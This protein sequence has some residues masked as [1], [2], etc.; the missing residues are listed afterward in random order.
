MTDT[1]DPRVDASIAALPAWQQARCRAVRALLHAADPEGL[2]TGGQGNAPG[3]TIA[4]RPGATLNAPAFMAMACHIIATN[5]AG[6]RRRVT[7][8]GTAPTK[9]GDTP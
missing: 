6:G 7:R 9:K 5:R 3:R 4:I 2:I 8:S 1:A